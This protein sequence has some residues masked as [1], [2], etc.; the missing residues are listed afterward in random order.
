MIL[1]LD[2]KKEDHLGFKLLFLEILQFCIMYFV[3]K[4]FRVNS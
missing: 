4:L 2:L 3:Y 1:V